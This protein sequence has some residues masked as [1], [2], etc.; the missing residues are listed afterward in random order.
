MSRIAQV[1]GIRIARIHLVSPPAKHLPFPHLLPLTEYQFPRILLNRAVSIFE[2]GCLL[3]FEV[4]RTHDCVSDVMK[5]KGLKALLFPLHHHY[6]KTPL[7]NIAI[8]VSP[9][10]FFHIA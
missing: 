5:R 6:L 3:L 8:G 7:L 1:N 4:S 2:I 10:S 9:I